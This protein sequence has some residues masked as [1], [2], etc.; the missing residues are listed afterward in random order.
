MTDCRLKPVMVDEPYVAAAARALGLDI[1]PEGL[2]GVLENLLR[3][4]ALAQPVIGAALGP[5]D[6]AAPVWLP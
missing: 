5:E 6:E 2:P 3:I 4:E 1:G